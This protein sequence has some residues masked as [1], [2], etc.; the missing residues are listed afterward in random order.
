M[1][2]PFVLYSQVHIFFTWKMVC[3]VFIKIDNHKVP[4]LK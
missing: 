2:Q 4:Y 1:R 3:A